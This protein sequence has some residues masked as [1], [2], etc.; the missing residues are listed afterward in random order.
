MSDKAD[1]PYRYTAAGV[2]IDAG[3]ALAA[4]TVG[5]RCGIA[6]AAWRR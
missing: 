6:I 1:H 2:D 5:H 3:Q 4:E